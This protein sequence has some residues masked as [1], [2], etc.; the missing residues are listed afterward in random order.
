[1]AKLQQ[2]L[3]RSGNSHAGYTIRVLT[4]G[5]YGAARLSA[6]ERVITNAL[7][8]FTQRG[9]AADFTYYEICRRYNVSYATVSRTI[10]KA[11]ELCF[12]RGEKPHSYELEEELPAPERYFYIPDWLRF[13]EFPSE[14]GSE[15]LTNVQ[16]E[17]LSYILHQTR[18]LKN[19]TS[20]QANIARELGVAASTV[21]EAISRLEKLKILE[22]KCSD[23]LH[24]RCANHYER[25]SY[26]IDHALLKTVREETEQ[27]LKIPS[28]AAKLADAR[29]DRERFYANRQCLANKH[30]DSVRKALGEDLEEFE[31]QLRILAMEIGKALARKQMD[32]V[33]RLS[34]RRL[35]ISEA[36]RK[37]LLEYGY[38]EEDLEPRPICKLCGDTGRL[39]GGAL[40]SCYLPPTGGN[41]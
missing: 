40:C 25:A 31:R 33:Q 28:R 38:T 19:W 23:P 20:T 36:R 14:N 37:F 1:M 2:K 8:S 21:S 16:I 27:H 10:Q 4:R 29:T 34:E 13:A 17:V 24:T 26:R 32:I 39:P 5:F 12:K 35:E 11:L 30:A 7:Y 9:A 18:K 22:V 6:L 41:P 15:D 3:N